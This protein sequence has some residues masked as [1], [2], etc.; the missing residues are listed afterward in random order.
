MPRLNW[1][2]I[3]Q[4]VAKVGSLAFNKAGKEK[5]E[6]ELKIHLRKQAED[7]L[8]HP[9][10]FR[11]DWRNVDKISHDQQMIGALIFQLY[12]QC[13]LKGLGFGILSTTFHAI[14]RT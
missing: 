5:N 8:Q 3:L 13:S 2:W 9:S 4:D 7:K 14:S 12:L 10:K 6:K 11:E 1:P